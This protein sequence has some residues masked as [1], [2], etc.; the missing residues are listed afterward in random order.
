MPLKISKQ[1]RINTAH[2]FAQFEVNKLSF[3]NGIP[4]LIPLLQRSCI[5]K[6]VSPFS[7]E[8]R[9]ISLCL[10]Y[11]ENYFNSRAW[12]DF[13]YDLFFE[14]KGKFQGVT[15]YLARKIQ[16]PGKNHCENET[17]PSMLINVFIQS[18]LISLSD[19]RIQINFKSIPS[20]LYLR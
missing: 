11:S 7:E 15:Q 5:F 8:K 18:I 12:E 16:P 14:G 6:T 2:F 17:L 1:C 19:K 9:L 4:S 3:K 13:Q 10:L 20:F